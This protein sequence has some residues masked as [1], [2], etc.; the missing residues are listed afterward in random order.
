VKHAKKWT[1]F[2][3]EDWSTEQLLVAQ[4][5]FGLPGIFWVGE[6]DDSGLSAPKPLGSL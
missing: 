1:D 2:S 5:I 6:F 3:D 4:L